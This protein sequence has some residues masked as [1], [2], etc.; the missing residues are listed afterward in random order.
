M[1]APYRL[2]YVM[3]FSFQ[4]GRMREALA[5]YQQ[6]LGVWPRL[7]GVRSV[8]GF[9]PQ[10]SLSQDLSAEVWLEIEDYAVLDSWDALAGPIRQEWLDLVEAGRGCVTFGTARLMGDLSGSVPEEVGGELSPGS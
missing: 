7:P 10:F 8:Q 9:V 4:T 5:W 2:H 6:G 1:P 3:T